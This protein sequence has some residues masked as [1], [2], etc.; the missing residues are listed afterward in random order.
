MPEHS[1]HGVRRPDFQPVGEHPSTNQGSLESTL[2][3]ERDYYKTN[4][5]RLMPE[6]IE[7]WYKR[8]EAENISH[9]K[10]PERVDPF[11]YKEQLNE[12]RVETEK[13]KTELEKL[14]LENGKLMD[15][16]K[17][18]RGVSERYH[19]DG[20]KLKADI[21]RLTDELSKGKEEH[22]REMEALRKK[23]SGVFKIY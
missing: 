23:V 12:K 10:H 17:R 3:Y 20:I 4:Y 13:L 14:K 7:Q 21:S 11:G 22:N 1:H 8:E 9:G 18:L 15:D 5:D 2:L 19:Q 16:G 6:Y